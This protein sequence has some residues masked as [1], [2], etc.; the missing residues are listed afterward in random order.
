MFPSSPSGFI[1]FRLRGRGWSPRKAALAVY[2]IQCLE[3]Q[4]LAVVPISVFLLTVMGAFFNRGP[5]NPV[6]LVFGLLCAMFGLLLFVDGLR[7]AVMP[8]GE[9]LGSELPKVC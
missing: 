8:L 7:I 9:M 4:F 1:A 2:Y 6:E 5:E 3:E